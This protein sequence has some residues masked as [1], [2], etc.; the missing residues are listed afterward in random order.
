M[1][2]FDV[3]KNPHNET[4]K[5]TPYLVVVQHDLLNSLPAVVVIPLILESK[6]IS[7]LHPVFQVDGK[8]VVM[9]TTEI[10]AVPKALLSEKVCSLDEQRSEII[11]AIDFLV[12]GF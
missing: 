9:A 10:V 1:A 11:N 7:K 12:T 6:S 8:S 5:V 3:Y 2:Q 4:K